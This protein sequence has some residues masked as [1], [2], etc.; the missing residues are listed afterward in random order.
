MEIYGSLDGIGTEFYNR[1]ETVVGQIRKSSSTT[2]EVFIE[3]LR[4]HMGQIF[5][6]ALKLKG[7]LL[8]TANIC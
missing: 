3:N 8:N 7:K 1:L 5:R 2:R 6:E 4:E